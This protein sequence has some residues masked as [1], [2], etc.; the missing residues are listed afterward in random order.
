MTAINT[1][2]I[3]HVTINDDDDDETFWMSNDVTESLLMGE[4]GIVTVS[5]AAKRPISTQETPT[6]KSKHALTEAY[7]LPSRKKMATLQA[8]HSRPNEPYYQPDEPLSP[9]RNFVSLTDLERD[10]NLSYIADYFKSQFNGMK[11]SAT[12]SKKGAKAFAQNSDE[13]S[14]ME[15]NDSSKK[16]HRYTKNRRGSWKGASKKYASNN[17]RSYNKKKWSRKANNEE[18]EDY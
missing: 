4:S 7:S 17:D 9:L 12:Y 11:K 2:K 3:I 5:N 16:A 13:E 8:I 10:P 15:D 18:G 14:D 1:N 6:P